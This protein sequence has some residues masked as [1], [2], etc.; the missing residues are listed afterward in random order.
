MSSKEYAIHTTFV[1]DTLFEICHE[2][3]TNLVRAIRE[4]VMLESKYEEM[5][6]TV[7]TEC[8]SRASRRESHNDP[9]NLRVEI[10]ND[11]QR[12]ANIS[13]TERSKMQQKIDSYTPLTPH[14][15]QVLTRK[16]PIRPA[17]SEEKEE[18]T[19]AVSKIHT[20][21][22]LLYTLGIKKIPGSYPYNRTSVL[23]NF[24][25]IYKSRNAI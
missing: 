16:V 21:L 15:V 13:A 19:K 6:R 7:S 20:K 14:E 17:T 22:H 8:T 24:N 5:E 10:E 9:G 2:E 1:H 25:K 11:Y 12:L 23:S 18:M 3:K 4:A